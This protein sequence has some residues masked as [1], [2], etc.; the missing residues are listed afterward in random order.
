MERQSKSVGPRVHEGTRK[1]V[2]DARSD[3]NNV[4]G[5]K[6]ADAGLLGVS[7]HHLREQGARD[8]YA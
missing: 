1:D 4:R 5:V 6:A 7:E 3:T 2:V 8:V